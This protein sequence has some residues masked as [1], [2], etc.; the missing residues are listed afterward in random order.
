MR[1]VLWHKSQG[2]PILPESIHHVAR[3]GMRNGV[4]MEVDMTSLFQTTSTTHNK[5]DLVD[6]LKV[7]N[8]EEL[9]ALDVN[10]NKKKRKI[11]CYTTLTPSLA[12]AIE[13]T[14]MFPSAAYV[15]TI[16]H[17]K[18]VAPTAPQ[19][20]ANETSDELFKRIGS[21]IRTSSPSPL[22]VR[23]ECTRCDVTQHGNT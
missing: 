1:F 8:M 2:I 14:D 10:Q 9:A 21:P 20:A 23:K 18:T 4:G 7:T 17:I 6:L 22:D 15:A 19:N 12:K 3:V 5:S 16:Q 13:L 11:K